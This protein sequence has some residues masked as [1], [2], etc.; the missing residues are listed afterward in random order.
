MLQFRNC[1]YVNNYCILLFIL[2]LEHEASMPCS[3]SRIN[4]LFCYLMCT[5]GISSIYIAS[6]QMK[7]YVDGL[8]LFVTTKGQD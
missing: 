4:A 6:F 3:F 2:P 7:H 8:E 5:K 1:V